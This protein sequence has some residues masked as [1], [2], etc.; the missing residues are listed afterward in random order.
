QRA[1]AEI[2]DGFGQA[3]TGPIIPPSAG[4]ISGNDPRA[5]N[6]A[7]VNQLML[8]LTGGAG[9]P[10]SDGW[11]TIVHVGNAGMCRHDSIEVDELHHPIRVLQRRIVADTEGA[12]RFRGAPGCL[13][14]YG[15]IEGC[16]MRV[17]WVADG[18]ITP[19]AGVRGGFSGG[20]IKVHKRE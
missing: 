18:T 7:F 19:A 15:P 3:E 11:L 1:I 8:G 5:E 13:V 14:E 16:R 6:A 9:T 10:V 17:I 12:G 20:L 2:A 4:V